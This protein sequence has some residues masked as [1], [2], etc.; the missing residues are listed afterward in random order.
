MTDRAGLSG[1]EEAGWRALR[2]AFSAI[3][4]ARFEEPTVTPEGWSPKDVMF[5]LGGWM[6]DCGDQLERMRAGNFDAAEETGGSIDA[7]NAEWFERSRPMDPEAVRTGFAA[8]HRRMLEEFDAMPQI[9]PD[10]REWFEESGALHY[11]KHV[12][13]LLAWLDR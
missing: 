11:R 5:H 1:E 4:S 13:D 10:A 8:A 6:D 2:S 7:Q 12:D 9:T 3:P